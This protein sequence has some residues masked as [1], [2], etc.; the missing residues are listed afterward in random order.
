[1]GRIA[2]LLL[3]VGLLG[4]TAAA[5]A[6]TEGLKLQKS[7][8][9]GTRVVPKVFSPVCR[10]P[11]QSAS[12]SFRLRHADHLTIA[13]Q[14]AAGRTVRK[15]LS[16]R[17]TAAGAHTFLW[18]GRLADGRVAP[19]GGYR[20]ALELDDADRSITLPNRIQVDTK[21]PHVW[22]VGVDLLKTKVVVRYRAS[23]PAH[24]IL[25]VGGQRVVVTYRSP[26]RGTMEISRLSLDERRAHGHLAVAVRD[27]AGNV[28]KVRVLRY[29]IRERS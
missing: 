25:F 6:V 29:V 12:I 27:R 2:T 10:C 22:S 15:L 19:D 23:E 11:T 7:P 21:P 8:I 4:G 28:S 3:V 18:N 13:I 24:G 16:D 26:L 5:F 1:L 20:P 17:E 14:D 9:F